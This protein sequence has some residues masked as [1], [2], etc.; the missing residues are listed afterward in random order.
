MGREGL[1]RGKYKSRG[2][3]EGLGGWGPKPKMLNLFGISEILRF[4]SK[5][6]RNMLRDFFLNQFEQFGGCKVKNNGFRGSRSLTLVPQIKNDE[7]SIF[8]ESADYKLLVQF[9]AEG[10]YGAFGLPRFLI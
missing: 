1:G 9:E 8:W 6:F 7:F 2:G 5:Y 4:Q 3:R 10:S